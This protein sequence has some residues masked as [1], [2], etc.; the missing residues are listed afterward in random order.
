MAGTLTVIVVAVQE[1]CDGGGGAGGEEVGRGW[2]ALIASNVLIT[3]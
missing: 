2:G 3:S 1:S